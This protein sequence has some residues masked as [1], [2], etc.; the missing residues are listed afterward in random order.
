MAG[1]FDLPTI[2]QNFRSH[3][4]GGDKVA[5][6][7]AAIGQ[8]VSVAG[9]EAGMAYGG[10]MGD[11]T[12]TGMEHSK[13]KLLA[14]GE[15]AS[16]ALG[17][18]VETGAKDIGTKLE[19]AG[20]DAGSRFSGAM[21]RGL[22]GASKGLSALGLPIGNLGSQAETMG[23]KLEGSGAKAGGALGLLSSVGKVSTIAIGVGLVGAGVAGVKMATDF[24]NSMTQ[25]VTGAGESEKNLG[26]VSNGILSMSATVGTTSK[27]LAS[28]MYLI[29][30]AGFHGAAG[31]SILKASAEGAQ[32]G[33]AKMAD[34][35]N[36]VT[37]SLNAYGL[38]GSDAG[39]IT[40]ELVATV[41]AGKMH[42]QDLATAIASV[43]PIAASSGVSFAQV[44]GAIATM[45]AQGMTARR[46]SMNLAAMIRSLVAPSSSASAEM[47]KLGLN[48]NDL[49][50]NLGKKG[51]TGTLADM[52]EA[53][54]K[55]TKGG[56]VMATGF[57]NMSPAAKAIAQDI[58][59]GTKS[60][61]EIGAEMGKLS[62]VQAKLVSGFNSQATS[63]TGLKQ[64]FDGAMKTMVG[65]ATGLNVAL[66]LGGSHAKAFHDN[67]ASV[68]DAADKSGSSITGFNLVQKD[69]KF[70]LEQGKAAAGSLVTEFGMF[71]IPIIQNVGAA[72][73]SVITFF[74]KHQDA[75]IALAV[76]IGGVLVTAIT[77]FVGNLV[78]AG[79][80]STIEFG[81][82]IGEA[83]G[84][85]VKTA[86]SMAET[87]VLWV[88]YFVEWA[89]KSAASMASWV[90][91]QATALGGWV[92]KSTVS[93][94][95]SAALWTGYFVK[96]LAQSAA[97][98]ATWVATQAKSLAS[99]VKDIVVFV[100][101]H[102]ISAAAYIA[103]NV[104]MA[105]SA[106]AAFIAENAATLGIVAGILALVGG[107]IYVATHW[108]KCWTDIKNWFNDAVKFLRSGF[109]S[110]VLLITG[111]LAPLLFL[112]LHWKTVWADIKA[113]VADVWQ[114][115]SSVWNAISSDIA[116]AWD[117][118][119]SFFTGWWGTLLAGWKVDIAFVVNLL[120]STWDTISS[121]AKTVW[122]D[123]T[124]F[125]A[126]IPGEILGFFSGAISWLL[127]IGS[128]ILT[129]LWNGVKAYWALLGDIG[130]TIWGWFTTA[131]GDATQWLEKTGEAIITGLWN[132]LKNMWKSVT[133]W[134]GGLAGAIANLKGP[135]EYD[136]TIL[137]PHGNAIMEGL[138]QGLKQGFTGKVAPY[139]SGV[140]GQIAGTSF[141]TGGVTSAAPT[142]SLGSPGQFTAPTTQ[143]N[144]VA[145][146]AQTV[147]SASGAAAG[148]NVSYQA[149]AIQVSLTGSTNA[150]TADIQA[151]IQKA[152]VAHDAQLV[153]LLQARS[154]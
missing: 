87:A 10:K 108:K 1:S 30:S 29:E 118:I 139:L 148:L 144:A 49:S 9:E 105:A 16:G 51:I 96:W 135:I 66:L 97:S 99:G 20:A 43:L 13:G 64:T 103:S 52:T 14:A 88:A 100:A 42:M 31:L 56:S 44:G 27:E 119:S 107:I 126:A 152:M 85:A 79:V 112:A 45:T 60:V 57:Q 11:G 137:V 153:N 84:W 12:V 92:V 141:S 68:K 6:D 32:V 24:Q 147:G 19:T 90:A 62:P 5:S 124:S 151:A 127:N 8:E 143:L 7:M 72:I 36:V 120:K 98:A 138:H 26:M 25:L 18:G 136:R 154:S 74:A 33:G 83:V 63:A 34:V 77:V 117:A 93:I 130:S 70:Q 69:L 82:M 50:N 132:G 37:S 109:G 54:L 78:I 86:A 28:G 101:K 149:G 122:N 53:I 110:L 3:V 89:A 55:N 91:Q 113:V 128:D 104:A 17:A 40:N 150:S 131:I 4:V 15:G 21:N 121:D 2:V 80:K 35:A 129:G 140:A 59:G 81:K 61:K 22:G 114:F 142:L 115:L 41:A 38:K 95:Q 67:V 116:A 73:A 47:Q 39:R 111:P 133:S 46:A 71:L 102:A 65:G 75:A 123:V 125:L 146:D 145:T 94:A 134:L 48:A 76:V 106:T 23:A 58:L